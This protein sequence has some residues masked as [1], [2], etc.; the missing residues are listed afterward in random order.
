MFGDSC[1]KKGELFLAYNQRTRVYA[2]ALLDVQRRRHCL[3]EADYIVLHASIEALGQNARK[4]KF[5]FEAHI[6]EHGC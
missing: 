2:E 6:S 1:K 3:S 4:A 5:W